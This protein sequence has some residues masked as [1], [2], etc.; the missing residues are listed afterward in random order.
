MRVVMQ[1]LTV[2]MDGTPGIG[3]T[4]LCRKLLKMWANGQIKHEQ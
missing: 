4:T 2:V 3:K 1:S